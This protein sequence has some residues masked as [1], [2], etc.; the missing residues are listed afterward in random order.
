VG[1]DGD[2]A[3]DDRS[4][5]LQFD[6]GDRVRLIAF[7][8]MEGSCLHDPATLRDVWLV[9][10]DFYRILQDWLDAFEAEWASMP[11]VSDEGGVP[12]TMP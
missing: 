12:T 3:F 2:E 11:K 7:R 4:Y 9:A 6:V 5:V 10:N 8:P 1:P